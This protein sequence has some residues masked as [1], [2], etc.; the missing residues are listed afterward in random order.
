[1]TLLFFHGRNSVAI[2]TT[3]IISIAFIIVRLED[4]QERDSAVTETKDLLSWQLLHSL[5]WKPQNC[6]HGYNLTF[7]IAES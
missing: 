1:M 4:I 7:F 2:V 5:S 3:V 6:C